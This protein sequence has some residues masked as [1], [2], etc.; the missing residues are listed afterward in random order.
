MCHLNCLFYCKE[1]PLI[2][3]Y[4]EFTKNSFIVYIFLNILRMDLHHFIFVLKLP[5][6]L[7]YQVS[8]KPIVKFRMNIFVNYCC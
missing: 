3:V 4:V 8:T 2:Y 5:K 6:I 1:F 7:L